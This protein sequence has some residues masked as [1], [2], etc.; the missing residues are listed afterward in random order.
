MAELKDGIVV[1][2]MVLGSLSR[3]VDQLGRQ[4]P[5]ILGAFGILKAAMRSGGTPPV[6][7]PGDYWSQD[8]GEEGYT[9]ANVACPCGQTPSVEVGCLK[10]CECER[11]YFFPVDT[12]LVFNSPAPRPSAATPELQSES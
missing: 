1:D 9:V 5:R 4:Q 6:E 12:V 7:V 8:V 10:V 11:A 3:P 2:D